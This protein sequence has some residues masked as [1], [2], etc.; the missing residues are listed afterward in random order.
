M[1]K[2][3]VQQ[4]LCFRSDRCRILTGASHVIGGRPRWGVRS[5]IMRLITATNETI[6]RIRAH[7]IV[8]TAH[9]SGV[10]TGTLTRI[11]RALPIRPVSLRRVEAALM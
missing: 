10:A 9:D 4:N 7:G 1:A 3:N 11:V 2:A 5:P 8:R 6:E